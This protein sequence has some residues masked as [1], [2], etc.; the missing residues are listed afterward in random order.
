VWYAEND[1][2]N[3]SKMVNH[4]FPFAMG[5][6]LTVVGFKVGGILYESSTNVGEIVIYEGN[7]ED[8]I[9][10]M[11][12]HPGTTSYCVGEVMGQVVGA[13]MNMYTIFVSLILVYVNYNANSE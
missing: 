4:L 1:K 7:R 12:R 13:T 8:G 11:E 5:V 9:E 10:E 3:Y 6:T 2:A